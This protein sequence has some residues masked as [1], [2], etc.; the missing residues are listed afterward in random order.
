[1][2]GQQSERKISFI[3]CHE[4][5]RVPQHMRIWDIIEAVADIVLVATL[6]FATITM[7]G[8]A[9]KIVAAVSVVLMIVSWSFRRRRFLLRRTQ[10]LNSTPGVDAQSGTNP[11]W[12]PENGWV[13]NQAAHKGIAC[14]FGG[15]ST[16]KYLTKNRPSRA[17]SGALHD[18]QA[19]GVVGSPY[20]SMCASRYFAPQAGHTNGAALFN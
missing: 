5:K 3:R 8:V 2:Y 20:A 10:H 6:L 19:R 15:R 14:G 17:G 1:M 12:F 18:T 7:P 9:T 4:A 11:S 16:M 13:V